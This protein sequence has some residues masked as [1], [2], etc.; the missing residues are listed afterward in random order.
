MSRVS[1]LG[2]WTIPP[3]KIIAKTDPAAGI[4][5]PGHGCFFHP[6]GS[7]DWYFVHLEYGR[8]STN[9]QIYAQKMTFNPD[10]TILP[11]KLTNQGVGALRPDVERTPNLASSA[12]AAASSV[13]PKSTVPVDRGSSLHR[14]ETFAPANAVDGS[15]G[16]RWM[17]AAGDASPWIQLDL[18]QPRDITRTEAYFVRPAAGHAYKLESSL[19]GKTWQP[20]GGHK[21]VIRRSPHRD[22]K[23]VRARYLKLTILQGE[24]GLWE[25]RV[26]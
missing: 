18:G 25:F 26:Y 17:A 12:S 6:H 2:P 7:D 15:N 13:L 9:R 20:Y 23:A 8:G 21:E 24:P 14:E 10:G 3:D 19:D 22:A 16:T 5:G 1:P 4:Y 11:I